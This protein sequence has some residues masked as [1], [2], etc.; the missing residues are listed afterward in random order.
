MKKLKT[1]SWINFGLGILF[2]LTY[3]S[4]PVVLFR[5]TYAEHGSIGIIG[6]ADNLTTLFL[7][8]RFALED[9][10]FF[11]FLGL[12]LFVGGLFCLVCSKTVLENCTLK[13][14][15]LS[16]GISLV[17]ATGLYCFITWLTIVTFDNWIEPIKLYPLRYPGSIIIG[18]LSLFAFILLIVIYCKL[19][20]RIFS[21]KGLV[22]DILT[23]ILVLP[24]F[25]QLGYFIHGYLSHCLYSN[26]H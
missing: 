14:T 24:F 8:Y 17:G 20:K 10:S 22:I 5:I 6:G 21:V 15:A 1:Y 2:L 23:C 7:T 9:V 11:L 16:L 4:L 18:L 3:I 26:Y 19:R 25:L 12:S 13:T